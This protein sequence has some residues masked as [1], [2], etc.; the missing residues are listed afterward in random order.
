MKHYTNSFYSFNIHVSGSE[1]AIARHSK[2]LNKEFCQY[3]HFHH[4]ILNLNLKFCFCSNC[5][6]QMSQLKSLN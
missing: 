1:H 5:K 3:L 6:P 4:L 2:A